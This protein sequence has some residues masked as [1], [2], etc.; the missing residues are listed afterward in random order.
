MENQRKSLGTARRKGRKRDET[1][2]KNVV[3]LRISD[4]EKLVLE[5][6]T[7]STRKN[8]SEIVRE[9]IEFWLAKRKKVLPRVAIPVLT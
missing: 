4:Q 2:L 6:I 1:A 7:A 8:V 3:S 5:K 9:A